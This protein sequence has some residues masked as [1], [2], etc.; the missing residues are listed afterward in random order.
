MCLQCVPTVFPAFW[1]LGWSIPATLALWL[2]AMAVHGLIW[3]ALHPNMHGLPDV[4]AKEGL[5]S[6]WLAGL[7]GSPVF[8]YLRLNH[9]G[10]HVASGKV[11]YNECCPGMD[12]LV[13]TYMPVEE[14]KPLVR[15][16]EIKEV[17][18]ALAGSAM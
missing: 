13:G 12:H 18:G 15:E 10:H 16:R 1:L 9:V 2:P 6:S 5:P 4:P 3:N 8:E 7:R 17:E 14:W 11:N